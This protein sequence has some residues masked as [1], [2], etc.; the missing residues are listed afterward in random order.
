MFV[1]QKG[2]FDDFGFPYDAGFAHRF[3]GRDHAPLAPEKPI[4]VTDHQTVR[5]RVWGKSA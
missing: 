2:H 3:D 5:L 1:R 4:G